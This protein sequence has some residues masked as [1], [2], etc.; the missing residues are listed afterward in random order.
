MLMKIGHLLLIASLWS[1]LACTESKKTQT[2][3]IQPS[4]SVTTPDTDTISIPANSNVVEPTPYRA[5]STIV[6]DLVHTKL[7]I[8]F[9]RQLQHAIGKAWITLKPHFYAT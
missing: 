1:I 3:P 7:D 8:K 9:D 2:T 6:N 4:V 5:S